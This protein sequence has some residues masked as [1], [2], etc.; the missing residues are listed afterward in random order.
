MKIKCI[1]GLII[2]ALF[3][4]ISNVANAENA[5]TDRFEPGFAA[6]AQC[7]M[8]VNVAKS[9]LGHGYIVP[10]MKVAVTAKETDGLYLVSCQMEDGSKQLL[11]VPDGTIV[12]L[13]EDQLTL[14]VTDHGA[15][16]VKAV[17][18]LNQSSDKD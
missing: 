15:E 10:G 14:L 4:F 2:A 7:Y 12:R 13:T 6:K 16:L 9:R 11:Q 5:T 8:K 1:V 18:D 17:A 3:A